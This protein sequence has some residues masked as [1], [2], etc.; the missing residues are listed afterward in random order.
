MQKLSGNA[1]GF[2]LIELLVVIC[3]MAI[4]TAISIQ[5]YSNYRQQIYNSSADHL[6]HNAKIAL[7]AGKTNIDNFNNQW[8]WAWTD[9]LGIVQGWQ[10]NEFLPGM[11]A[12]RYARVFVSYDTWCDNAIAGEWCQIHS[13]QAYHCKGNVTKLWTEWKGHPPMEMEWAFVGGC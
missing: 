10:V 11:K 4:L 5:N 8:F 9:N 3:I 7:E 2:T 6:I 1:G 13:I 12:E